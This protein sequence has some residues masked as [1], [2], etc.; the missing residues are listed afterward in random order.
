MH[1]YIFQGVYINFLCLDFE[2]TYFKV[3][4]SVNLVQV[5]MILKENVFLQCTVFS[6]SRV[7]VLFIQATAANVKIELASLVLLC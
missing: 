3:F 1:I 6:R 5:R 4:M 2:L 7:G